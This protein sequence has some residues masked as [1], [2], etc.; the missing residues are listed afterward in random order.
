MP[1]DVFYNSSEL[2]NITLMLIYFCGRLEQVP[3]PG[4]QPCTGCNTCLASLALLV[5]CDSSWV[6]QNLRTFVGQNIS[7]FD[8]DTLFFTC[9]GPCFGIR[10]QP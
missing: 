6:Y 1:P 9:R 8:F 3:N 5:L 2:C 10:T 7:L 4:S